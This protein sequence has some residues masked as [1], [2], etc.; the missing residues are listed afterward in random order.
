MNKKYVV[1]LPEQEREQ[2]DAWIR[3]GKT[4]AAKITHAPMLL[5]AAEHR[6]AVD[7][8]H[9]GRDLL[10]VRYPAAERVRVVCDNLNTHGI[11][12]LYAAYPPDQARAR[13]QRLESHYTPEHGG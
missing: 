8:A 5:K 10:E 7:W 11:G 9:E 6:T 2:L 13:A 12:A 1:R 4:A 3:K